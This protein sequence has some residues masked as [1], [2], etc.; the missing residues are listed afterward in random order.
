MYFFFHFSIQYQKLGSGLEVI[1]SLNM[2]YY[3]QSKVICSYNETITELAQA[4]LYEV[5]ESKVCVAFL[6]NTNS[7]LDGTITYI[8]RRRLLSSSSIHQHSPRLQD[9]GV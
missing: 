7:R 3:Q 9:R 5:P 1:I 2:C 4:R 8:Q 6:A